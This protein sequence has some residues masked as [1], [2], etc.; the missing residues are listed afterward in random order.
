KSSA[1]SAPPWAAIICVNHRTVSSC[2]SMVARYAHSTM[3]KIFAMVASLAARNDQ[4]VVGRLHLLFVEVDRRAGARARDLVFVEAPLVLAHAAAQAVELEPPTLGRL[5]E[6]CHPVL[7]VRVLLLLD[8]GAL[9]WI[10]MG[11]LKPV[12]VGD[13]AL[14][15]GHVDVVALA[16]GRI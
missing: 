7:G 12:R 11:L 10:L 3:V 16:D 4:H 5:D 13:R 14:V 9:D 15:G 8:R 1:R 6:S 2:S